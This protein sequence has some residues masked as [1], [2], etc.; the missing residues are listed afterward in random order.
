MKIISIINLKGGVA[1][2]ISSIN[3]AHILAEVHNKKVLIIDNDKQ[4]NTSKFFSLGNEEELSIADIMLNRDISIKEV[5]GATQYENIDLIKANMS[6]LQANLTIKK[7][8]ILKQAL[9]EVSKD[10]DYCIIDNAPDINLS[11]INAIVA[12]NDIL[13]PVKADVFALD[14]L[15]EIN[16]QINNAKQVNPNLILKGCF[17]TQ[18]QKNNAN[19]QT[20][21]LLIKEKYPIFKTHIRR[22]PKIDESTFEN[23]PILEY[24][25]R[26][27]ATRD[28]L[29]LVEEYL[30]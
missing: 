19:L 26:C 10:Y 15:K 16:E 14:G 1:K 18:W 4:G 7:S 22:T 8:D 28:Y 25:K 29:A 13:I 17:I 2:T 21:T 24:S 20:E 9:E 23:K 6:L 11:T 27:G 30:N 5:I 3:I 12:S